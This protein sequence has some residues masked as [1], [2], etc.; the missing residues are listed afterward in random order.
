MICALCAQQVGI[1]CA[2]MLM[3][4]VVGTADMAKSQGVR[5]FVTQM[6]G[7]FSPIMIGYH[8]GVFATV[9]LSCRSRFSRSPWSFG[10]LHDRADQ[11]RALTARLLTERTLTWRCRHARRRRRGAGL[12]DGIL[13]TSLDL[14]IG[15]ER[16]QAES[17]SAKPTNGSLLYPGQQFSYPP[18]RQDHH[19]RRRRRQHHAADARQAAGQ[20]ARGRHRAERG[21]PY[22]DDASASRSCQRPGRRCRQSAL[23]QR[24][25]RRA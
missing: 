16:P 24:R 18:R 3:H 12:S 23:P 25:N 8:P 1:S 20:S 15:M 19:D 7:A 5:A 17:W 2:E 13:K 10:R 11:G 21:H 14:V 9:P 4:S 6:F 22:R